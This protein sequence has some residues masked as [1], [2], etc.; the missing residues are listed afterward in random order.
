MSKIRT[1]PKNK[2]RPLYPN[3]VLVRPLHPYFDENRWKII[4]ATLDHLKADPLVQ[5]ELVD[6]FFTRR[7]RRLIM[8]SIDKMLDEATQTA[9]V[10]TEKFG[11]LP[12]KR[13]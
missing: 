2:V 12:T 5:L 8:K 13:A 3:N 1:T 11:T 10:Q 6:D 4:H 9:R 7:M